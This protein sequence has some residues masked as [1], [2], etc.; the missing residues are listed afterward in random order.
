MDQ[1]DVEVLLGWGS[2]GARRGTLYSLYRQVSLHELDRDASLVKMVLFK[3]AVEKARETN[4]PL[5]DPQHSPA[6]QLKTLIKGGYPAAARQSPEKF[7]KSI[8]PLFA[9]FPLP[10]SSDPYA[11]PAILVIP[12]AV[13]PL[14]HQLR[15]IH[16]QSFLNSADFTSLELLTPP[17][18]PYLITEVSAGENHKGIAVSDA[19]PQFAAKRRMPLV[20]EEVVALITQTRGEIIQ[21]HNLIAAGTRHKKEF[22]P[23]MYSAGHDAQA[24]F[25][26]KL[27]RELPT[28]AHPNWGIPSYQERVM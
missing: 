5:Y 8:D 21:Y 2:Q 15:A 27:K 4:A 28:N 6:Y 3:E 13:V 22:V 24:G 18:T 26:L 10:V 14:E 20:L 1:N 11:F 23:D 12:D 25:S 19:L 17:D 9:R 7:H 16:A